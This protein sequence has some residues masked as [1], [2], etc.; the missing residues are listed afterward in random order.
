M[1]KKVAKTAN[2]SSQLGFREE[3][4]VAT[5]RSP[6]AKMAKVTPTT[7]RMKAVSC[8]ESFAISK[9]MVKFVAAGVKKPASACQ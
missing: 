7:A 2:Q 9:L 3:Q 8:K 5:K 4:A 6:V 1:K